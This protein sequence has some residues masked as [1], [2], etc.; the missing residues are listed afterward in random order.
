MKKIF[1]VF[2]LVFLLS[3][4]AQN[5]LVNGSFENWTS[6][7]PDGWL[8]S[9]TNLGIASMNVSD[10]AQDGLKS[11][12]LDNS[13]TTHRRFSSQAVNLTADTNYILTFY[14]K[15]SGEV[16]NAWLGSDYSSYTAYSAAGSE[17]QKI[18]YKFTTGPMA[19]GAEIIFSVRSTGVE[20]ILIDNAVLVVDTGGQLGL[21]DNETDAISMSTDW[22]H[23]ADFSTKGKAQ[24][25][26]YN[27]NGQ[28]MQTATGSNHFGVDVS[29]LP[30]GVYAVKINIDGQITIKK[31]IK[32]Q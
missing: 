7:N 1:T 11:I 31:A 19:T 9:A 2:A 14:V 10:D 17:W 32:K 25:E 8:G 28:L 24:V 18:T 16:R 3:L 6:G 30:K 26:I 12:K 20:G 13:S 21:N 23:H 4:S 5:L 27:L 22:T 29:L 15:G